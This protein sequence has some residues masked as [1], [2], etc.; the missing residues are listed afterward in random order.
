[1]KPRPN[2]NVNEALYVT[3]VI[4]DAPNVCSLHLNLSEPCDLLNIESFGAFIQM[5]PYC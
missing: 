4:C 2:V 5:V 3:F 1:M